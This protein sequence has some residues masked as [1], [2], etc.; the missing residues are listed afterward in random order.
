M[1]TTQALAPIVTDMTGYGDV[2]RQIEDD[3]ED[4][5]ESVV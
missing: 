5:R 2:F 4:R 3:I 1:N